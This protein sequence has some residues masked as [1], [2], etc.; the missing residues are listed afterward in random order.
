VASADLASGR[1]QW[2]GRPTVMGAGLVLALILALFGHAPDA[3]AEKSLVNTIG[4]YLTGEG[5]GTFRRP[6]GIGINETGAGGVPAGTLYVADRENSRIQQFNPDGTF[7]RT[8]GWGVKNR[9][10]EFQICTLNCLGGIAGAGAGQFGSAKIPLAVAVDQATG[11]IY[12]ADGAGS[13]RR[14]NIFSAKGQFIGAF[15]WGVRDRSPEF[16]FCTLI[17]ECTP[18]NQT[19]VFGGEGGKFGPR[20]GGV[21]V[22]PSG[23]VAVADEWNARVD[24]F[25]PEV[26]GETVTGME[27]TAAFGWDVVNDAT[28][29]FEICTPGQECKYGGETSEP[30]AFGESSPTDIAVDSEGDIYALDAAN[31]RIEKFDSNFNLL[32]PSFGEVAINSTF[33][34]GGLQHIA[35]DTSEAPNHLLLSASRET[36]EEHLEVLELDGTGA[37]VET[38]GAGLQITTS[39]GLA[40]APAS[41]GGN[42]Y[43]STEDPS[44]EEGGNRVLVLNEPPTMEP[45]SAPGGTTATFEG[46]VVSNEIETLYH[47]EY[48]T[49]GVDWT[50]VPVPDELAGAEPGGIPVSAAVT[51]LTGSQQYYAR[52]VAN[53]AAGGGLQYSNVVTFTTE[54]AAPG[55]EGR[56]ASAVSGESAVLNGFL[57]P[58]NETTTYHFEYGPQDCALGT[59]LSSAVKEA[60][61]GGGRLASIAVAGL[62]PEAVYHFRLV[63]SNG[64]GSTV[65]PDR[66]FETHAAGSNLPDG[67]RYELVSPSEAGGLFLQM[68]NAEQNRFDTPMIST[69]GNSALFYTEGTMLPDADGNGSAEAYEAVRGPNG[70]VTHVI[71]P[72][73]SQSA[74]PLPGGV[75]AD[76]SLAFWNVSSGGSLEPDVSGDANVLRR[77]DGSFEYIGLGSIGEEP[78]AEDRRARGLWISEGGGHILFRSAPFGGAV[79]LAP[80]APPAGTTAIYDR[81]ADGTTHVVSLLRGPGG[82]DVTPG[83]GESAR[84]LG[85]SEDGSTVVF[86]IGETIWVRLDNAETKEVVAGPATYAGIGEGGNRVFYVHNGDLFAYSSA[87]GTT[88]SIGSGGET[89]PV[90]V[91]KDGSHVYFSSPVV[92]ASGATEGERNLYVWD[93]T[94]I[95]YVATAVPQDFGSFSVSLAR[96]TEALG[97][98]RGLDASRTT[99]DG[100]VFV[101]QSHEVVGYPYDSDGFVE[102]YRYDA[103]TEELTCVSCNPDGAVATANAELEPLNATNSPTT[104]SSRFFNVT[105]DG[106]RVFF[107]SA[108]SLLPEDINGARDVYEWRNGFLSLISSGRSPAP[109]FLYSITP[110]GHDVL[111]KTSETLLPEDRDGGAGSIYDAR[112]E[113]GF[114]QAAAP[115]PPCID[116]ACQG[117]PASAPG[118]PTAATPTVHGPGNLPPHHKKHKRKHK[119]HKH[120]HKRHHHHS[121]RRASATGGVR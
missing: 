63:A 43:L 92:L 88:T 13:V 71:A 38:H 72:S 10:P 9:E 22:S 34:F 32:D 54:P 76:H 45:V 110:D 47:F 86:E 116:E 101:F 24:V 42:I 82:E 37:E 97:G 114:S 90:N 111:F 113:G 104:P 21:A 120:H 67:R 77:P 55:V 36:E 81:T 75:S 68:F 85:A 44:A 96:W 105:D 62:A 3:H 78:R 35:V 11:W 69:D 30:G 20:I 19:E 27:F 65:G 58:E 95:T 18:A 48:S 51:G 117:T 14:V 80:N 118:L 98:Q 121:S 64:T 39:N 79:P 59:C 53:R 107:N 49:N 25:T 8:W 73:G 94:T 7:A 16:Q 112:V 50:A 84:Y 66:E 102:I 91:S 70:W 56:S 15:G 119:K 60:T 33:G 41:L 100:K 17:T 87:T 89:T 109:S 52:L 61:G 6:K 5:P 57:D 40:V 2:R 108:D 26:S 115:V 31:H 29:E 4:S 74:V 83:A 103:E 46:S 93:G 99:P 28:E 12:V 23:Q 106:S 1:S